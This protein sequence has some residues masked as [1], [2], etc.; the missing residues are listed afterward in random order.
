MYW[1]IPLFA[2]E[3]AM[4][5]HAGNIEN[6]FDIEFLSPYTM[7]N[8]GLQI[9]AKLVPASDFTNTTTREKLLVLNCH[10][11]TDPPDVGLSIILAQVNQITDSFDT[12][13]RS[14]KQLFEVESKLRVDRCFENKTSKKETQ[15]YIQTNIECIDKGKNEPKETSVLLDLRSALEA[16]WAIAKYMGHNSTPGHSGTWEGDSQIFRFPDVHSLQV[17]CIKPEEMFRITI[18]NIQRPLEL[19][20]E[21]FEAKGQENYFK[22]PPTVVCHRGRSREP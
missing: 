1:M 3:P 21:I 7:T 14:R 16:G 20:I 13:A 18:R 22:L 10:R 15:I 2:P 9:Q 6:V 17:A 4:F 11:G 8:M 12:F 19:S 5:Q